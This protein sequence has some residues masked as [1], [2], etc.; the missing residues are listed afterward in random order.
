MTAEITFGLILFG[1]L[2]GAAVLGYICAES[3]PR[4]L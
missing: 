1:C 2:M 4:T 3:F